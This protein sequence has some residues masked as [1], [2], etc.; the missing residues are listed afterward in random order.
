MPQLRPRCVQG[1]V[2]LMIHLD[3][4][5]KYLSIFN[6]ATHSRKVGRAG[7][8]SSCSP[9]RVF[10]GAP[11]GKPSTF[12]TNVRYAPASGAPRAGPKECAAHHKLHSPVAPWH[13]TTRGDAT[14]KPYTPSSCSFAI[15]VGVGKRWLASYYKLLT[16][17][18]RYLGKGLT[19]GIRDA[20]GGGGGINTP[21]FCW[22]CSLQQSRSLAGNVRHSA[23][24]TF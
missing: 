22:C 21:T 2:N 7:F 15:S 19:K 6:M 14:R 18:L 16:Y 12:A 20:I 23:N 9:L 5:A 11:F 8:N 4:F 17:G 10:R 13:A 24:A 3:V 1:Y